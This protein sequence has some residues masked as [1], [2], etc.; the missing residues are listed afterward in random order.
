MFASNYPRTKLKAERVLCA[1]REVRGIGIIP[2]HTP[3][4]VVHSFSSIVPLPHNPAM[5]MVIEW[6]DD[7]PDLHLVKI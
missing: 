6:T 3:A 1:Q 5:V 2:P 7:K 4:E